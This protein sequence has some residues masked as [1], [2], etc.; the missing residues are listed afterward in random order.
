MHIPTRPLDPTLKALFDPDSLP[1]DTVL[2]KRG[3][4]VSDEDETP[5]S[6]WITPAAMKSQEQFLLKI[7]TIKRRKS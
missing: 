7:D 6:K 4:I 2:D 1:A 3:N 5:P